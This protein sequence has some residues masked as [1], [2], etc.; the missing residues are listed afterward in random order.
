MDKITGRIVDFFP[1][2]SIYIQD[3]LA[4]NAKNSRL[5]DDSDLHPCEDLFLSD[6]SSVSFGTYRNHF[7]RH[8]DFI[9]NEL[10][11]LPHVYRKFFVTCGLNLFC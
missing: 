7:N 5:I 8:F 10:Q 11:I 2:Q 1:F 4:V 6:N 9:F 3:K